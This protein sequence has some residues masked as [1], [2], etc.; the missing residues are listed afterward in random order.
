M[1]EIE[2]SLRDFFHPLAIGQLGRAFARHQWEPEESWRG[3]REQ[4]LRAIVQAAATQCDGWRERFARAGV[5]PSEVR[6]AADLARLPLLTKD[7]VRTLGSRLHARDAAAHQARPS[8]T[9]GTTGNP[10]AFLVDRHARVLEFVYYWRHWSWAGFRLGHRFAQLN[11]HHFLHHG[12]HEL[13]ARWQ[14]HLRRLMLNSAALSR[15]NVH[16]YADAMRAQRVRF[17]KGLASPL[18]FLALLFEEHGIRDLKLQALFST[19]ENLVPA[20]RAVM[21]RVFGCRVLDSYGLLEQVASISECL[22]G[23]YHVNSDYCHHEFLPTAYATPDGRALHAVVGTS[24][25]N[26][27]MPLLR[28][29]VGDLVELAPPDA[30]CRCGRTLPL[31]KAVHGRTEDAVVTPDGRCVTALFAVPDLVEGVVGVQFVQEE[32]ASLCIRIVPGPAFDAARERDFIT[33]AERLVGP[34]MRVRVERVAPEGLKRGP[35]G[36]I[37]LVLSTLPRARAIASGSETAL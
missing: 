26:R 15:A 16:A 8:F 20:R 4:R 33:W 7:D 34:T 9:S 2:F 23:G 5:A 30:R 27:S 19:G 6:S 29:D 11:A 1:P 12:R 3:W 22:D 24:L 35:T 13:V 36:K 14:P 17:L 31:V 28:Y 25:H 21:E 10:V 18:Y 37:P 32:A